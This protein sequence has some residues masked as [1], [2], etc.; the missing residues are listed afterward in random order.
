MLKFARQKNRFVWLGRLCGPTFVGILLHFLRPILLSPPCGVTHSSLWCHP[1][2]VGILDQ[3]AMRSNDRNADAISTYTQNLSIG[4][5]L[6]IPILVLLFPRVAISCKRWK[7]QRRIWV[8]PDRGWSPLFRQLEFFIQVT[9][10]NGLGVEVAHLLVPRPRPFVYQDF[11][12]YGLNISHYTS[13]Y[14]GHTS[15]AAAMAT[16]LCLSLRDANVAGWAAA[17]FF[18]VGE[19]LVF[20]TGYLRMMAGRH[21]FTDVVAGMVAGT[22]IAAMT[23]HLRR[24]HPKA[25]ASNR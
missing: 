15:S 6:I 22:G 16:L 4:L 18:F 20:T 5:A 12:Y 23:W 13:F 11:A 25:L 7:K 19:V 2:S 14:S 21:F 24:P 17:L 3:L 10:W 9:V 8:H 1:E